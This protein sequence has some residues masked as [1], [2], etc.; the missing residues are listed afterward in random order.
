L[1]AEEPEQQRNSHSNYR[2]N[3]LLMKQLINVENA[4][5]LELLMFTASLMST[6]LDKDYMA[7]FIDNSVDKLP[8]ECLMAIGLVQSLVGRENY[9]AWQKKN[10][11]EMSF[12]TFEKNNLK[13]Q[14]IVQK[15]VIKELK[16]ES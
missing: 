9:L 7:Q 5:A 14:E 16:N 1:L 8:F 6:A 4:E 10:I 15:M 2:E 12:E 3:G 11:N 13:R